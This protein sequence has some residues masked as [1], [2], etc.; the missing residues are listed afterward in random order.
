VY[1]R[2]CAQGR[3]LRIEV[4][5]AAVRIGGLAVAW[6]EGGDEALIP[7]RVCFHGTSMAL[8]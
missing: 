4:S 3:E 6:R 2:A 5:V 1:A 7:R 8:L